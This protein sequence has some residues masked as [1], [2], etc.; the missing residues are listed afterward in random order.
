MAQLWQT[1]NNPMNNSSSKQQY[2]FSAV[3]RFKERVKTEGADVMYDVPTT[4][5]KKTF[6]FGKF[7]R[8]H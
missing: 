2:S 6:S 1:H 5:E 3:D 8:E 7:K 4:R